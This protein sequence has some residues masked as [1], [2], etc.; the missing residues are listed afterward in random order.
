MVAAGLAA[1]ALTTCSYAS[2]ATVSSTPEGDVAVAFQFP[3]WSERAPS[4]AAVMPAGGAFGATR[5]L[6]P[7]GAS[8]AHVA[9]GPGG[10]AIATWIDPGGAVRVSFHE[11]GGDWGPAETLARH[12]ESPAAAI[13]PHGTALVVWSHPG[14]AMQSATRPPDG[15]FG[16]PRAM[17]DAGTVRSLRMDAAGNALVLSLLDGSSQ[18]LLQSSYRPAGGEF[19]PARPVAIVISRDVTVGLAMNAAG[20]AIAV[21]P[22]D[23]GSLAAARRPAGGEFGSAVRV[24]PPPRSPSSEQAPS[25]AD[26]GLGGDGSAVVT[27]ETD[28]VDDDLNLETIQVSAAIAVGGGAFGR[29]MRLSSPARPGYDARTAIDAAGD[30]VIAWGAPGFGVYATYRPAGGSFGRPVRVAGPRLGGL[31]DVSIYGG[32]EARAAWEQNDGERIE[33]ATRALGATGPGAPAQVLRSV[34]AYRRLPHGRARCHPPRT[35]TL[36]ATGQARVYS[37]LRQNEDVETSRHYHPKYACLFR[38][39]KPIALE[40]GFGD[41]TNLASEPPAMA[42]KGPLLAYVYNDEECGTCGGRT[43]IRVLDLRTG[44]SANGFGPAGDPYPPEYVAIRKM[45]LRRDTAMAYTAC[46]VCRVVRVFKIDS[47]ASDPVLVAKGKGIDPRF[48][49]LRGRRVQWRQGG[50]I[51]SAPLR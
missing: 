33:L 51:R 43:G 30:A 47:G 20:D 25:L 26:V 3:E 27:W 48:L 7:R 34:P 41:F 6:T 49:R 35:R 22:K 38:R 28:F 31:P 32:G 17:P 1:L 39:G 9:A 29:P 21:F 13:D 44:R 10:A 45:V 14:G 37:D 4:F 8:A 12:G 24:T 46:G 15:P 16:A 18:A 19:A 36:L 50:G 42:L 2:G 5:R 23:D 40:Y 11:A